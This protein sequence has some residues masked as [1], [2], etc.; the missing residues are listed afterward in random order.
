MGQAEIIL[1]TVHKHLVT[2]SVI[3]YCSAHVDARRGFWGGADAGRGGR[4]DLVAPHGG[5][6][7]GA[8]RLAVS[9]RTDACPRGDG[10]GAGGRGGSVRGR[11]APG[12][13]GRPFPCG[14]AE[15]A[16]RQEPGQA[17]R[18]RR[19]DE[20]GPPRG[21]GRAVLPGGSGAAGEAAFGSRRRAEQAQ[22]D[23]V[24]AYGSR[25]VARRLAGLGGPER[26][27]R[28]SAWRQPPVA[29]GCAGTGSGEGHD[30][31]AVEGERPAVQ[32]PGAVAGAEGRTRGVAR[33]G[34]GA[35]QVGTGGA[36]VAVPGER[37]AEQGA[38]TDAAAEGHDQRAAPGSRFPDPGDPSAEP[39]E[40][41]AVPRAGAVAGPQG[42]SYAG[43]PTRPF[44]SAES[45]RDTTT[46]WTSSLC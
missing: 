41:P 13:D 29:Q 28:A 34:R 40:R 30:R 37:P 22:H 44:C 5:A 19:G 11:V 35:A 12:R 46:R 20:G 9:V 39:G 33:G 10:T 24:A 14:F 7:V 6:G 43:C 25:P 27:D 2:P 42:D 17:Q 45:W 15:V 36:G 16:A 21:E 32:S 18:G 23:D 8:P 4:R 3:G 31:A 1:N 38:G 26:Y